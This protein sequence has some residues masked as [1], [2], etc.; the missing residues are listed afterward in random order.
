MSHALGPAR[1]RVGTATVFFLNGFGYASWVPRLAEVKLDLALSEA[2]LGFALL[3]V[4]LGALGAMPLSGALANRFGS[5]RTTTAALVAFAAAQV[6]IALAPGLA[7][8]FA[9]FLV[10]GAAAGA[11]DVAMNAQGVAVERRYGRPIMSSLHGM[12]SLGAMSGA[13]LTGAIAIAEVALLPHLVVIGALILAL[14]LPACRL[15]LPAGFDV[16]SGQAFAWPDRSVLVLGLIGLCALLAEGAVGDWSAVYLRESLGAGTQTA[17]LAFA[18]FSLMMAGG[19]FAGDGLIARFGGT[20]I[21]RTGATMAA[22]GLAAGLLIAHPAAAIVAFA[23]VGAGIACTFPITLSAAARTEGLP[24][25]TAIAAVCTIGY[26]GFL[27]GPPTIGLAAELL[28]LP[29]ALGLLVLVLGVIGLL[30]GR[31]GL[32]AATPTRPKEAAGPGG[33]TSQSAAP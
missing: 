30:G 17:A 5:R 15:M 22:L 21:A 7:L 19:R 3:G 10:V 28:G 27:A 2:A 25:G 32:G 33:A 6:L 23:L 9:A 26:L 24:A 18:A 16:G 11:L 29:L 14:G 4:A 13:A 31:V 8:L 20:R 1:A 12:F